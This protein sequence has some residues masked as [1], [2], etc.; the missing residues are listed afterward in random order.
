MKS[1]SLSHTL[2]FFA[3]ELENAISPQSFSPCVA[4]IMT[5]ALAVTD[6]M[7]TETIW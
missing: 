7:V 5:R 4:G 3:P 2:E 6:D 1:A